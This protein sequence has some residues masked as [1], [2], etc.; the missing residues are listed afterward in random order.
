MLDF[1][2]NKTSYLSKAKYLRDAGLIDLMQTWHDNPSSGKHVKR[3]AKAVIL[4]I[5]ATLSAEDESHE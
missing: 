3:G 4:K 1:G 5:G 2:G